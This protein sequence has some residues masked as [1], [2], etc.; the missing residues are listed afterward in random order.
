MAKFCSECGKPLR[1]GA[2]FCPECGMK[3]QVDAEQTAQPVTRQTPEPAPVEQ[4]SQKIAQTKPEPVRQSAA[5]VPEPVTRAAAALTG[6][7]Q[8][9]AKTLI[10]SRVSAA[11][12]AGET[13]LGTLMP[14]AS[15]GAAAI[16]AGS[17]VGTLFGGIGSFLGG[18]FGAVKKPWKLLLAALI[19]CVW[20]VLGQMQNSDEV[21]VKIASWVTYAKGGLDRDTTAGMVGGLLGKGVTAAAL[22]SLFTG[23]IPNALRGIGKLFAKE[24]KS[25][26]G[27]LFGVIIGAGL[28]IC[29]TGWDTAGKDTAM[30]G[31]SGALLC[32]QGIGS[33]S[34][35]VY[36]LAGAFTAKAKDGVRQLQTG[37]A[38]SMAAGMAAGF[39]AAAAFFAM[40]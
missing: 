24:K 29:F 33:E 28:Y 38:A 3:I 12:E 34:G 21:W 5:P 20:I 4:T 32:L 18:I 35:W 22:G 23:G 6:K 37:K 25:I 17:P 26:V 9:T 27:A 36:R 39:A 31:V 16:P 13:V 2:K 1:D 11:Q 14:Q 30:A 7:A 19:A 10:G 15:G 8:S 40:R